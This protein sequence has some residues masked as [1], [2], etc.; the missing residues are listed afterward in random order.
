MFSAVVGGPSVFYQLCG[1]VTLAF[2]EM[3]AWDV[4]TVECLSRVC[5]ALGSTQN[6][7]QKN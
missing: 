7:D 5:S 4:T 2:E 3:L 1:L 6:I